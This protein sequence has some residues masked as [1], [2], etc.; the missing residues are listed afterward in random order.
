V[1]AAADR[2]HDR[3]VDP[4]TKSVADLKRNLSYQSSQ[5][6]DKI[7]GYGE[8]VTGYGDRI[9]DYGDQAVG[10]A[11][12]AAGYAERASNFA[13]GPLSVGI[14][15]DDPRIAP[16]KEKGNGDHMV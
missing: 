3:V 8:K 5:F 9:A 10:Y 15:I 13:E 2:I 4:T 12:R 6:G 1:D 14:N 7:S 16:P 11:D